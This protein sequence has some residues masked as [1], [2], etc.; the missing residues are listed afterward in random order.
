M[1]NF[2]R[3]IGVCGVLGVYTTVAFLGAGAAIVSD[4]VKKA[5]GA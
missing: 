3:F 4:K 5:I 1:K 2:V